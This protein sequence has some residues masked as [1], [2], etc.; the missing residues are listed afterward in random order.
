MSSINGVATI[1]LTLE[2]NLALLEYQSH[3]VLDNW[4]ETIEDFT[5]AELVTAWA[6][7]IQTHLDRQAEDTDCFLACNGNEDAFLDALAV[8]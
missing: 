8:A 5:Q 3:V 6:K 1:N 2:L 4:G 7:A